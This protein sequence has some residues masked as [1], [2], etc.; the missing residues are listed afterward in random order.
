MCKQDGM[1]LVKHP[2]KETFDMPFWQILLM[3]FDESHVKVH[4]ELNSIFWKR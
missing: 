4:L 2:T 1:G 3:D